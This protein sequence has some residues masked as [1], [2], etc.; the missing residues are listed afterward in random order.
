MS[1]APTAF[2]TSSSLVPGNEV[3][4]WIVK[5]EQRWETYVGQTGSTVTLYDYARMVEQA[6]DDTVRKKD[7]IPKVSTGQ[8]SLL[9]TEM[10]YTQSVKTFNA[11]G[12]ENL[13]ATCYL[14]AAVHLVK[15]CEP[16]RDAL[17]Q[18]PF[19]DQ[20]QPETPKDE[21]ALGLATAL[22][23]TIMEIEDVKLPGPY[24]PVALQISLEA[25]KRGWNTTSQ[26]DAA[27]ALIALKNGLHIATNRANGEIA[28]YQHP[29]GESIAV[30]A[31]HNWESVRQYESDSCGDRP[32][33]GQMVLERVC[34]RCRTPK[35]ATFDT[36]TSLELHMPPDL[37]NS[38]AGRELEVRRL[39]H[40]RF[41]QEPIGIDCDTCNEYNSF[42][43]HRHI[44]RADGHD[45][46]REFSIFHETRHS[47]LQNVEEECI[48]SS[49]PED[50]RVLGN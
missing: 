1:S 40:I 38:A 28:S 3:E 7:N 8:K 19:P 21:L 36:F 4:P 23:T 43:P 42:I 20:R 31:K 30:S 14:A 35:P 17:V 5:H 18:K 49:P 48:A 25:I 6:I 50:H 39:L 15:A 29:N 22:R 27:E 16:F 11:R 41:E 45:P 33:L 32:F 24:H 13:G 37:R 34:T 2:S 46:R 12:I 47:I 10:R 9:T 44:E 26:Q